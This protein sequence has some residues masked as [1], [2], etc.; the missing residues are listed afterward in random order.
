MQL[1]RVF[2][3]FQGCCCYL[4][5]CGIRNG[6][7]QLADEQLVSVGR[8]FFQSYPK[9]SLGGK[10]HHHDSLGIN[11]V[12]GPAAVQ[13]GVSALLSLK[14]PPVINS[15]HVFCQRHGRWVLIVWETPGFFVC[16]NGEQS[17]SSTV[18]EASCFFFFHPVVNVLVPFLSQSWTGVIFVVFSSANT[19]MDERPL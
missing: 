11:R 16:R 4:S 8:L 14:S 13:L 10:K 15:Y 1:K 19:K 2:T 6:Q 9:V 3:Y 17:R 5:L 18:P 12:D 7:Q